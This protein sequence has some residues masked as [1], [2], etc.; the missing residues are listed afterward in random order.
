LY[1]SDIEHI[2]SYC[3]FS[4]KAKGLTEY[5]Y[6]NKRKEYRRLSSDVCDCYSYDILKRPVRRRPSF[7]SNKKYDF[8]ID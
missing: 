8:G 2:C 3:F 4:E 1:S 6:C 7:N 5:I